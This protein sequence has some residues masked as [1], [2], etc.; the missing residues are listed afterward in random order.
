[1][2]YIMSNNVAVRAMVRF[3]TLVR[4]DEAHKD[5]EDNFLKE[6]E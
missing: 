5:I 6:A 1:M 3:S 4:I 2:M